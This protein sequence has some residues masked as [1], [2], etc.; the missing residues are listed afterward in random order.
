MHRDI[1]I[2]IGG[3]LD[4]VRDAIAAAAHAAGRSSD[5]VTLVAVSKR[6]PVE[7]IAA[8][9]AAGQRDFGE[10]TMQEALP[11]LEQ[12]RAKALVWHFIGHLQSNKARFVPGNFTWLHSLDSLA[13]AQRLSRLAS[14]QGGAL[15]ALIEVN[16][17]RDPTRH[18]VVREQLIPL[19]EQLLH[20]SLPGIRLR[21]LM[22]IGP[23][24]A[25][26]PELRSAFAEVRALRD[27]CLQRFGPPGFTELSMGM[28]SDFVP[29]IRE[30]ATLI[31]IGTAIFGSRS[32]AQI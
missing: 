19:V 1:A 4:R 21:G 26:E 11:K 22:A 30:G 8:A 24:P 9:I 29:A 16:I 18:G 12:F 17:A 3:N 27:E 25:S 2:D 23:H 6:Q 15:D 28:S 20:A 5:E 13:L 10:S 7:L 14:A 32:D 31:R